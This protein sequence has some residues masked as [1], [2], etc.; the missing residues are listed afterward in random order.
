MKRKNNR[1]RKNQAEKIIQLKKNEKNKN[2]ETL[3]DIIYK[4]GISSFLELIED[5]IV[6]VCGIRYK[7]INDRRYYRWGKRDVPLYVGGQKRNIKVSRVRDSKKNREFPLKPLEE[8]S[9]QEMF[10]EKVLEQVLLGVSTRNYYK[11]LELKNSF[12]ESKSVSKSSVSRHFIA[13]SQAKLNEWLGQPIEKEYPILML[14]GITF[15]EITVI[16]ALGVD[17]EGNKRVLGIREGSTEN[18]T[19]CNDLLKNIIE[20]GFDP[21]SLKLAVVDG[22]TG[23]RKSLRE[24]FGARL[25]VQRCQL[26]KKRN[27]KGY[28]PKETQSY[29]E[30]K[31]NDAYNSKNYETGK[32]KLIELQKRL[33]QKYPSAASSLKEGLEETLTLLKLKADLDT[34]KSLS[35]TNLIENLMGS[36][37]KTTKNAKR[38]RNTNM[39]LRWT[40]ASL[41]DAEKNFRKLN[42]FKE[43]K[44][45]VEK[46]ERYYLNEKGISDAA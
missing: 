46:I 3:L 43:I 8:F 29:I 14:D 20:R 44:I 19:V 26:H 11:S 36:V 42:G 15:K 33:G 45:L 1:R 16:V 27:V 18:H 24:F 13:K 38:W 21:D 2:K 32:R 25:L 23:I 10:K 35:S 28:L 9:D 34:R 31:M 22:G 4:A 37:R 30:A 6:E 39:I 17:I 5:Y 12:S 41:I 7:N 40:A